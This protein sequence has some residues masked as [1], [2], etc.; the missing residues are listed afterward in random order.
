MDRQALALITLH[1]QDHHL[2]TLAACATA[3]KAWETLASVFQAKSQARQLQL[4]ASSTICARTPPEAL[5]VYASRAK[6]LR[7]QLV[8]AGYDVSEDE[9]AMSVLAGLPAEYDM[10]LTALDV[11]GAVLSIDIQ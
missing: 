9:L 2:S 6:Q 4:S 1:V 8:A 3:R 7:D 10:L 11:S 5:T